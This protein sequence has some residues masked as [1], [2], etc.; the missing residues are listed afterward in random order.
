MGWTTK[1]FP[2]ND[3]EQLWDRDAADAP[4][5]QHSLDEFDDTLDD[6]LDG[7]P[8]SAN[9]DPDPDATIQA[10]VAQDFSTRRLP[11]ISDTL[12]IGEQ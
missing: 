7:A 4:S 9:P 3:G 11:A 12:L 10:V 8:A 5:D 2:D 1:G 6:T